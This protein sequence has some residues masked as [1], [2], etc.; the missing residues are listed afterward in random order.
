MSGVAA[1]MPAKFGLMLDGCSFDSEH[2]IAVYGYYNF[3]G[4]AQYPLLTM[5][6]LVADPSA[7]HSAASPV[8]FLREM[9]MRDYSKRLD[10]C[11]F[12]VGDNCA[13]NQRMATLVGVPLVGCA[14]HRLSLAVQ[15]RFSKASDDLDQVKKLMTKLKGLNQSAKL[16]FKTP[17]RPFINDDDTLADSLPS[18]PAN[19]RLCKFLDDLSKIES[20]SKELQSSSVSLLDARVYFDGLL[21][22]H[23]SF[24][25]HL[26]PRA[27]SVHSPHFEA[28][29]VK[30]LV[31]KADELTG[32]QRATSLR[33]FVVE[34]L[35]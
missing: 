20:V 9:L 22:L 14:S 12:V 28:A 32:G 27:P 15:G 5:A 24:S 26:S 16:R 4:K 17:L 8:N 7:H 1:E 6:P 31:G 10:D 25:T 13:T 23:P 21:E 11:L 18:P 33:P 34:D 3:N 2:Y 35:S 29:C 30:V 19:R